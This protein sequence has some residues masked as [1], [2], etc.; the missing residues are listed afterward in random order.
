MD[1]IAESLRGNQDLPQPGLRL[2]GRSL[3]FQGVVGF[4]LFELAFYFA[5]RYGMSFSNACA[6]PFWFPDSVLLCALLLTPPRRWWLLILAPLPIRLFVAVPPEMPLWFLLTTFAIDSA[7]G[8]LAASVLR[9]FVADPIRLQTI[10]EI[11]V[12]C[13]FVVLLIPA[14]SA[15]FGAGARHLLG[16]S[17][18]PAWQQW[19]MGNAVTHVVVTPMLF[20]WILGTPW[21]M[22]LPEPKRLVEGTLL[23]LGLILTGYFAFNTESSRIDFAE[24]IFYAPVPFLFWAAIRFGMLGASGAILIIAFFSVAAA[25][26]GRGPFS[27]ESP[28]DNAIALQH[29]LLLRAVPLYFVA[30]LIEQSRRDHR[31]LRETEERFRNI[32]DA[33]PV[34][35]WITGPDKFCHFISKSWLD[36]TGRTLEQE[37]GHGWADS[38]HEED[39]KHA[40]ETYHTAFDARQRFE[41]EYRL[42]R[43]DGEYRWVLDQGAPRYASNGE[44]VGYVGTAMDITDRR[45]VE[46]A[47]LTLAH[48]QRIAML[49]ELSGSLAHE[50]NQPLAAILSNAQAAQRFLTHDPADLAELRDILADIVTDDRRAGEVIKRLRQ[51]F[52]RG[53]IQRQPIDINELVSAV[54]KLVKSELMSK[55]IALHTEFTPELPLINGDW[56]Q[57]QQVLLNLI[58]NACYAMSAAPAN[59]RQLIVRTGH[60]DGEGVRVTVSDQGCGIPAGDLARIFEPFYTTRAEGMGLGLTVCRTIIEFHRGKLWAASN[61]DRGASLHFSLPEAE[62]SGS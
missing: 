37:L 27:D 58:T 32:A 45:R 51:L 14:T 42:R 52:G 48:A 3:Y 57:L 6:S 13:L 7:K 1:T 41:M 26:A 17:Y 18:W 49:G 59:G 34:M 25:I 8:L 12:F 55:D 56:V 30:I 31:S 53:E 39:R 33:A 10:R 2:I 62:E 22:P 40:I 21:K 54:L 24:P 11:T 19:L 29:F 61:P 46:E 16:H 60:L 23:A 5:Y 44:F 28:G 38:V 35:I 47:T 4:C 20:C 9:R 50:L 36:F 15:F 43:Y